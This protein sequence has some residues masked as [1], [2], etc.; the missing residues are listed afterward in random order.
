MPESTENQAVN[1]A[2]MSNGRFEDLLKEKTALLQGA[3]NEG[4]LGKAMQF[5]QEIQQVR[6]QN[7]FQEVGQLT[8]E[9][10]EAIKNFNVDIQGQNQANDQLSDMAEATDR[11]D[12]VVTMTEKA[13]NKTMDLT[14]ECL[15]IA[16]TLGNDAHQLR[17]EWNR[18]VKRDMGADEFRDLYWRM[19]K[20]LEQVEIDSKGM[21][22]KL[23]DILLA[24]DYQ[25]LTGQVIHR[26]TKLVREMEQSLVRLV[27]MA[28]AVDSISGIVHD[29]EDAT[30]EDLL[31]GQ[32]PQIDTSLEDVVASQ[33]D[34][35]DLLSSLGF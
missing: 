27:T 18:L 4:K 21:S 31:K 20:F 1:T 26:V 23:T 3:L 30:H 28:S 13:A 5:V 6:D 22:S 15:P 34:V 9:L 16:Q 11:L 19:D 35:D 8:R 32:G 7:L 10:H 33:D 29:I 2:E 14:E 25:D 17:A 24:Q 12:Y